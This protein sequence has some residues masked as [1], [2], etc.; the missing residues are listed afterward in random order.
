MPIQSTGLGKEN[1]Q[2]EE[3]GVQ[4]LGDLGEDEQGDPKTGRTGRGDKVPEF[5]FAMLM[6][7]SDKNVIR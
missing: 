3:D 4:Q 1:L 6:N 7:Q 2:D 5:G